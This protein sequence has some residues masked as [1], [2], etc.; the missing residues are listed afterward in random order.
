MQQELVD[1]RPKLIETSRETE[2][3]IAIIEKETIEVEEKKK[4]VEADE[5]VANEAAN[6]AKAIKVRMAEWMTS[7]LGDRWAGRWIWFWESGWL[8]DTVDGRCAER[9]VSGKMDWFGRAVGWEV[10]R[11]GGD[12]FGR[13][14]SWK[15][16]WLGDVL[17]EWLSGRWIGVGEWIVGRWIGWEKR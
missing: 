2:E 10:D 13:V 15:M 7:L 14:V 3:L 12:W 11:L 16:D 5:A 6:K 8:G 9:V 1:L 4:I 17:G